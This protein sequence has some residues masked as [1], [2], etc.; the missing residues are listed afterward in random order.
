MP[1]RI[2]TGV[3]NFGQSIYFAG[4]LTIEENEEIFQ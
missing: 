3:N 2:F 1:F 4:T